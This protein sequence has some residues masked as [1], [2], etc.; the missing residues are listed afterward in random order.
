MGTG[1]RI[2]S[3]AERQR[4]IVGIVPTLDMLAERI[5]NTKS[6]KARVHLHDQKYTREDGE[7]FVTLENYAPR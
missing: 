5:P 4:D 2:R 1:F 3:C 7:C 6:A